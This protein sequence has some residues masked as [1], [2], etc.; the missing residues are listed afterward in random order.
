GQTIPPA[1]VERSIAFAKKF[2]AVAVPV[3]VVVVTAAFFVTSLVLWGAA[4]AFGAEAGFKQVLALWS[5]ANLANAVGAV[6]SLPIILSIP[7]ASLTR[8]EAEFAVKSNVGAFLSND[9]PVFVRTLAGS[10]DVFSLTALVLL[11][12]GFRRLPGLSKA[13]G[14]AVPVVLWAFVVL[15]KAALAAARA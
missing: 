5:H 4:R 8:D 15:A 12:I 14:T 3:L 7:D 10:I 11:V 1:A 9:V 2:A 6:V 13:S